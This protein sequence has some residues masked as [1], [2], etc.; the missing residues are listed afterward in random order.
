MGSR[1]WSGAWGWSNGAAT[2][3]HG[4]RAS[5]GSASGGRRHPGRSGR[6]VRICNRSLPDS[7]LDPFVESLATRIASF[8]K[9]AVSETKR[10]ADVASLPP[11]VEIAPEWNVCFASIMRPAAQERIKKLMERGFHKP[12]DVEDRLGYHVGQLGR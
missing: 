4:T 1:G 12:G 3:S 10:F 2:A 9:R 11:D 5:T 6:T 8:D 7:D